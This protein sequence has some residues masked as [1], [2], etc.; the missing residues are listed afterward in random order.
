MVRLVLKTG[1]EKGMCTKYLN[2]A[3]RPSIVNIMS[4]RAYVI[5][6]REK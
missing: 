4:E 6:Q 1:H 5:I 2:Y 3:F